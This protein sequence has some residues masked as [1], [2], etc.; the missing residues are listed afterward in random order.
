MAQQSP[1]GWYNQPDGTRRYWDGVQW[2]NQVAPGVGAPP[3]MGLQ[4]LDKPKKPWF[5]KWWVWV[6]VFLLLIGIGQCGKGG[7]PTASTTGAATT[8][9]A[10]K[11]GQNPSAEATT[12]AAEATTEAAAPTQE[13]TRTQAP[14]L[15]VSQQQA[16]K[17]AENYL[18]FSSF[19]R[20]GLI[21]QLEYEGFSEADA[22]FAVDNIKV[23]W[24]EQAAKSAENYLKFSS[25]SRKGL[26]EQLE[27]E[28]FTREQAEY[29]ADAVG[30]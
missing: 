21:G 28:G 27:F 12:T 15:T 1:A 18:R 11:T 19:S 14:R 6:I 2:T 4:G 30:L 26:I 13:P 3:P 16:V 20:Q 22:T 25:F 17:S 10:E 23:D 7:T 9:T 5:K 29:G 8:A 24:M